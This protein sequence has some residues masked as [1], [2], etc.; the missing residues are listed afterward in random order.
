MDQLDKKQ[1]QSQVNDFFEVHIVDSTD[2]TNDALKRNSKHLS[3]GFVLIANNQ[4]KGKGRNGNSFSSPSDMGIYLSIYL[5]PD[6]NNSIKL[7]LISCLATA[8]TIEKLYGIKPGIKWVNDILINNKKVCGILCETSLINEEL[9][10]AI[11]GIGIN[12][13]SYQ[14][15]EE[16]RDI[17]GCVEDFSDKYISRNI[18]IGEMLNTFYDLYLNFDIEEYK[19]YSCTLNTEI[20]VIEPKETYLAKAIDIDENGY[21]IVERENKKFPLV[22]GEIHIRPQEK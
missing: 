2:S 18:F 5:K 17:A 12:L 7:T 22:S 13:H 3:E 11:V 19:K 21:L 8:K 14:M 1:I 16:I 4:S 15:N 20:K 6:F 10:Y 9:D